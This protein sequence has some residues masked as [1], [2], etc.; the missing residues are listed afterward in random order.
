M[1]SHHHSS[2]MQRYT[3]CNR[4]HIPRH[5]AIYNNSQHNYDR[6]IAAPQSLAQLAGANTQPQGD[7]HIH[8]MRSNSH[9]VL[10]KR[11][12]Q[13][14]SPIQPLSRK[15]T[16]TKNPSDSAQNRLSECPRSGHVALHLQPS[17]PTPSFRQARPTTATTQEVTEWPMSLLPLPPNFSTPPPCKKSRTLAHAHKD[18]GDSWA[19]PKKEGI[20][21]C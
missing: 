15:A 18:K 2:S 14:N 13:R 16:T 9:I 4:T 5:P 7:H 21:K 19:G 17:P 8:C 20:Q 11:D 10:F 12:I 6:R 1:R 3:R